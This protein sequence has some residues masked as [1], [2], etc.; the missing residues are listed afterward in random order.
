MRLCRYGRHSAALLRRYPRNLSSLYT[1]SL[2]V[3]Q[4]DCRWSLRRLDEELPCSRHRQHDNR[5]RNSWT[6]DAHTVGSA[7][8][9]QQENRNQYYLSAG[10]SVR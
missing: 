8:A 5:L 3:G 4:D 6:P 2:C 1:I 9:N 7:D 10:S